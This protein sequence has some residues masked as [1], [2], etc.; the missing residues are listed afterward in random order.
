MAEGVE[1]F[2]EN[3]KCSHTMPRSPTGRW[4]GYSDYEKLEAEAQI[5]REG[6]QRAEGERDRLEAQRD[7]ARQEVLE[8]V[9]KYA[10][11]RRDDCNE[12]ALRLNP[13]TQL[14]REHSAE[15]RAFGS[16][17]NFLATLDPSGEQG[18]EKPNV[19]T[20]DEASAVVAASFAE[21]HDPDVFEAAI[22]RLGDWVDGELGA[23]HAG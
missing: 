19:L 2:S 20:V 4:V 9:R 12:G 1:R 17:V 13:S 23:S 6:R 11:K 8:E 5:E 16:V 21:D 18:E 7:Q 22:K 10:E 15:A 3:P 14:G